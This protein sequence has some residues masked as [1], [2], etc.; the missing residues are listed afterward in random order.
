MIRL[1]EPILNTEATKNNRRY[2]L[3]VLE[4]IRDQINAREDY[5]N[6]GTI[7]YPEGLEI[8]LNKVAFQ[9]RNAVVE[10][11]VLYADIETLGTPH[12]ARLAEMIESGVDL[13]FR[14]GGQS[15]LEGEMP[16]ETHNLLGVPKH[17][18]EDYQ[19]ITIA[20]IS[21]E[22]DAVQF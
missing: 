1:K 8:P 6:L 5:R 16:M 13:R 10:D 17:V 18:S 22:E 15:T 21:P 7:G 11:G 3:P 14:P 20:A 9:Y 4:K 2:P 12:G 19:I